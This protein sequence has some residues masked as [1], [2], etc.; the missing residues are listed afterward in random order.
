M[1]LWIGLAGFLTLALSGA[2][3]VLARPVGAA[4]MTLIATA[5]LGEAVMWWQVL[6]AAGVFGRRE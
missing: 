3:L 1:R 4:R 2:G 6:R 5:S